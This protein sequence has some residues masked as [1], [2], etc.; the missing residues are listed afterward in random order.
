MDIIKINVED[1]NDLEGYFKDC[2]RDYLDCGQ[3]Y[4]EEEQ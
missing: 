1:E 2:G 3:G 4:Y